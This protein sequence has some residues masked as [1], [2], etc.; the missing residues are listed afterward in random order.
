MHHKVKAPSCIQL[1]LIK[2][3]L[4]QRKYFIEFI[5]NCQ[6]IKKNSEPLPHMICECP[7]FHLL[8]SPIFYMLLKFE[9]Q[10]PTDYR[11]LWW[12]RF[13]VHVCAF[14]FMAILVLCF[15]CL[16]VNWQLYRSNSKKLKS[17]SY[18]KYKHQRSLLLSIKSV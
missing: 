4:L 18:F 9:L 3:F 12:A 15:V 5:P 2:N 7:P 17:L 8:H 11:I 14:Y 13:R 6:Y 1:F 16:H 10:I